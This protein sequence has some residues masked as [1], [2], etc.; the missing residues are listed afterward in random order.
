MQRMHGWVGRKDRQ[1]VAIDAVV[2]WNDGSTAPV[3]LTDFSDEGC[4]IEAEHDFR[5]GERMQIDIP[6]MGQ[7]KAQVRWALP[8]SAGAMF[9]AESDF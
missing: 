5:I 4:R 2:H 3:K 6:R 1:S 8:G 7:V 9:L